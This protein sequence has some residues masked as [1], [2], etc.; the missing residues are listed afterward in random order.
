MMSINRAT[1][2]GNAGGNP[3][4][5]QSRDGEIFFVTVSIATNQRWRD[6]EGEQ[7]ETTEWHRVVAWGRTADLVEQH[8]R[9]GD[10]ILVEGPI[11]TR[12]WQDSA[13]MD[14]W[15][16]ELHTHDVI[17]LGRREAA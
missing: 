13:G 7:H 17:F 3:E 9:K 15:T 2:L 16:T 12:K 10:A 5:H 6:K 1:I 4:R 8:V 11:K 14:Q